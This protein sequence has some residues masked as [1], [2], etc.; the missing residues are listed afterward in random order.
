MTSSLAL[1]KTPFAASCLELIRETEN[2]LLVDHSIRSFLFARALAEYE[3]SVHDADYDEQ[4]LFAAC[5]LHDLGLGSTATA[6]ARFEVDGADLAATFLRSQRFSGARTDRIW[7]A[8]A[9]HSTIGIAYRLGLLTSLVHRGVFTDGGHVS[10]LPAELAQPVRDA[11]PR[12][13]N[14]QSIRDAVIMHASRS[15]AAAPRF[16][17]GAEYL[18]RH[19]ETHPGEVCSRCS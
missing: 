9:L 17:M 7:E 12:P 5:I 10:Y 16:S 4:A 13:S 14:D 3:G 8:I 6:Q 19:R 11:Y 2:E 15:D 1:P 18:R